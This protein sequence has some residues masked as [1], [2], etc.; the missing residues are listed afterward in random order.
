VMYTA[1]RILAEVDSKRLKGLWPCGPTAM[2]VPVDGIVVDADTS[3]FVCACVRMVMGG[4]LPGLK[5]DLASDGKPS[6]P[7]GAKGGPARVKEFV[8]GVGEKLDGVST[9]ASLRL[10]VPAAGRNFWTLSGQYV[11]AKDEII[12]NYSQ[13]SHTPDA[14]FSQGD[15]AI[16][17]FSFSWV[18]ELI[19]TI[20]LRARAGGTGDTTALF[21]QVANELR[22]SV[23]HAIGAPPRPTTRPLDGIGII[24]SPTAFHR[25]CGA[26]ALCLFLRSFFECFVFDRVLLTSQR[27]SKRCVRTVCLCSGLRARHAVTS[28]LSTASASSPARTWQSSSVPRKMSTALRLRRQALTSGAGLLSPPSRRGAPAARS[29]RMHGD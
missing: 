22:A 23:L 20:G 9:L 24:K 11:S 1:K 5:K 6:A 28:S 19:Y 17:P 7:C 16:H 14:L 27:Q 8:T 25:D 21:L 18:T 29:A 15:T 10:K 26:C 12:K 2:D 4:N 13:W 3:E